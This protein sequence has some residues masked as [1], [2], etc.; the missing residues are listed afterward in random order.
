MLYTFTPRKPH[1]LPNTERL[2]VTVLTP[3]LSRPKLVETSLRLPN[4]PPI[5][6]R[7]QR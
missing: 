2:S 3:P 4:L 5:I 6:R 1:H 7:C